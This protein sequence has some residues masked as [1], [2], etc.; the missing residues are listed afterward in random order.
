M[1]H[2]LGAYLGGC[3]TLSALRDRCRVDPDTDCWH[4]SLHFDGVTPMVWC[5]IDGVRRKLRGRAAAVA[6]SRGEYLPRG[7]MAWA[8]KQCKSADCV[9]PAHAKT[10]PKAQ[11]G[12][13]MAASGRWKGQPA[14]VR[15]SREIGRARRALTTEQVDY[16]K[17]SAKT[18]VAL[19][20]ELGVSKS[21][22]GGVRGGKR[23]S[24]HPLR[25]AS[26]FAWGCGV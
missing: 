7:D 16:I 15:A 22:V 3:W 9:N 13:D 17:A 8:R 26:V 23:Y 10:G 25:G 1:S 21:L 18:I 20:A 12:A 24:T 19:A 14:K 11:W 6:L 2:E 4:W 5:R